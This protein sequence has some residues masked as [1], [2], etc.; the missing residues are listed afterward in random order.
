MF[1]WFIVLTPI[2]LL[3]I[4]ALLGFVGCT[5]L[6]PFADP[7]EVEPEPGAPSLAI[8]VRFH[9]SLAPPDAERFRVQLRI[10]R[11]AD[12]GEQIPDERA[13]APEAEEAGMF[14]YSFPP[15]DLD[16]GLYGVSCQVSA[17]DEPFLT[18][19]DMCQVTVETDQQVVFE[20]AQGGELAV[21]G[22]DE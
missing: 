13:G 15:R 12:G 3:P 5:L 7:D 19:D 1:D 4:V 17:A 20:A 6:F 11:Q 9:R 2:L 14:V 8:Q 16:A 22:C 10:V 21:Q 18:W